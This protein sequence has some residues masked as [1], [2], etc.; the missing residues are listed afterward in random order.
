MLGRSGAPRH[1]HR[2]ARL[3]RAFPLTLPPGR[4]GL[5]LAWARPTNTRSPWLTDSD[6]VVTGL[7]DDADSSDVLEFL[8]SRIPSSR[9]ETDDPEVELLAWVYPDL[10]VALGD[11][12]L[13]YGVTLTGPRQRPGACRPAIR[14]RASRIVRPPP[15]SRGASVDS[16]RP[17][18]S[19]PA[20]DA[21]APGRWPPVF[22]DLP[23]LAASSK[24]LM[25]GSRRFALSR[26][27]TTPP[28]APASVCRRDFSVWPSRRGS[29]SPA[30]QVITLQGRGSIPM[31]VLDIGCADMMA[32]AARSRRSPGVRRA[33]GQGRASGCCAL[34]VAADAGRADLP[35]TP[36]PDEAARCWASTA[37]SRRSSWQGSAR[38]T[39]SSSAARWAAD[40]RES[41]GE[42]RSA[43]LVAGAPARRDG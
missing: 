9:S 10:A 5:I 23:R 25:R 29:F 13:R 24:R 43:N 32:K 3:W 17:T 27:P 35:G 34:W 19:T 31:A 15:T 28:A 1:G 14:K 39:G 36:P 30:C 18:N 33:A 8:A 12:G 7:P 20:R 16:S 41:Y 4:R 38:S 40:S 37:P 6:F 26:R 22:L 42:F 21:R 2:V 11:D